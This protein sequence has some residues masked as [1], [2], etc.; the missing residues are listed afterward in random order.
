MA[1]ADHTS[2]SHVPR[3]RVGGDRELAGGLDFHPVGSAERALSWSLGGEGVF[4]RR[5]SA[6]KMRSV[7]VLI[8][9]KEDI[10]PPS[11]HLQ[12]LFVLF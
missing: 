10:E 8:R 12:Q 11:S 6:E 1:A 3:R 5:S 7:G 4:S 9:W 2:A